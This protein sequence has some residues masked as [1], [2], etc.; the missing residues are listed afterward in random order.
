MVWGDIK[1]SGHIEISEIY[2]TKNVKDSIMA[3]GDLWIPELGSL[4]VVLEELVPG[5]IDTSNNYITEDYIL[6]LQDSEE[7]DEIKIINSCLRVKRI[8]GI[9]LED[10]TIVWTLP[11]VKPDVGAK[12]DTEIDI[13][14]DARV[15]IQGK[16][17]ENLLVW[18]G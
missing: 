9:T 13:T 12:G 11:F 10:N 4:R 5:K 7:A 6:S 8:N 16:V 14:S 15:V 17:V 1:E 18:Y 3:L 2:H